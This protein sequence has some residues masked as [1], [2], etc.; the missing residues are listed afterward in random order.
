MPR[1]NLCKPAKDREDA[2]LI[3]TI[4]GAMAREGVSMKDLAK[5]TKIPYSTLN[6]RLNEDIN[7]IRRGEYKKIKKCLNFTEE[8][9]RKF[10]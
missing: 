5:K 3:G 1:T 10:A 7:S 4:R 6:K 9:M 8:E 2:E